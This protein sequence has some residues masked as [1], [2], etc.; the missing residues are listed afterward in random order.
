M[1]AALVLTADALVSEMFFSEK[2]LE[3]NQMQQFLKTKESVSV[4]ERGYRFICDWIAMNIKNFV[5]NT[6][7]TESPSRICGMRDGSDWI[8]INQSAFRTA[9]EEGGY[10]DRA[11]LS[12][13][14]S[15]NLIQTRGRRYTKGK[16]IAGV[17]IECVKLKLP[18]VALEEENEVEII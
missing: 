9:C 2:P 8:F 14:K 17:L 18:D 6:D 13:M 11:L 15:K 1:A 3:V 12:Y 5:S 7:M 16:R 10:N 4:G